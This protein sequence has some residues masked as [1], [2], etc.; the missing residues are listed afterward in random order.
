MWTKNFKICRQQGFP[1][2][3][4]PKTKVG[5]GGKLTYSTQAE[6]AFCFILLERTASTRLGE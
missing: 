5:Y 3:V 4:R 2:L 6:I 1:S